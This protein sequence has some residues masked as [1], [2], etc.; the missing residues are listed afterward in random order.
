MGERRCVCGYRFSGAALLIGLLAFGMLPAAVQAQTGDGGA[1]R[2]TIEISATEKIQVVAEVATVKVG[3]Q[4]QAP[5]KD[6]AYAE[7]TRVTNKIVKAL[8]D[9]GVPKEAIETESLNLAKEED[10]YG[11]KPRQPL[12]YSASQTL[13]IRTK[14]GDAQKV[15]DIAVAAGANQLESVEWSVAEPKQLETKAYGAA[16]ARAKDM[17]QQTAT[18]T[19]LKL[20]EIV[21]I[22]NADTTARFGRAVASRAFNETVEVSAP[23]MQM[24]EL[25]PAMVEREASVT[26]TYAIAP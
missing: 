21:S 4:N 1:S 22:A 16:L 7:N 5:T 17:A 2:K 10:R 13:L 25:H 18:Q 23:K 11:N 14:A 8:L 15:V 24:L 9:A 19:G 6:T 20:G 3:Y 26:V 12:S